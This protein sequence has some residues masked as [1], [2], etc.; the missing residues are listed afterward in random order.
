MADQLPDYLL[1]RYLLGELPPRRLAEIRAALEQDA[2]ARERLEA[3]QASNAEILRQYPAERM[4]PAI[5]KQLERESPARAR[6]WQWLPVFSLAAAAVALLAVA[7]VVERALFAPAD[8]TRLKGR[9]IRLVVYRK[10]GNQAMPLADQDRARD[11]DLLQIAYAVPPGTHGVIFSLDG[12]GKVTLHF[13]A[14]PEFSTLMPQGSGKVLLPVAY[15]LDRAPGF[16]R[17][18]LMTA[19][20]ELQVPAVLAAAREVAADGR[21]ARTRPI[22]APA[23]AEQITLVLTKDTP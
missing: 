13:P 21:T 6:G 23:G 14:A 9:D 5:Q 8:T 22:P 11:G 16:E 17:F 10:E 15:E 7:P 3:L 12:G 2:D 4:A 20:F 1:E 18:V 19:P